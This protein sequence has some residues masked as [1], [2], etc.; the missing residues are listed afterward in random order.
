MKEEIMVWIFMIIAASYVY[1][2]YFVAVTELEKVNYGIQA[3]LFI[4]LSL[5]VDT[6][7]KIKELK[8]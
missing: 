1:G 8:K 6:R 7:I 4:L 5:V 3:I 2:K